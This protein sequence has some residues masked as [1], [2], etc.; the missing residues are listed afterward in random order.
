MT[1]IGDKVKIDATVRSL[2]DDEIIE[3][4]IKA[5]NIERIG[6]DGDKVTF[7]IKRSEHPEIEELELGDEEIT[8]SEIMT[9]IDEDK[10]PRELTGGYG[11]NKATE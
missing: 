5:V 2:I 6:F 4:G 11:G 3:L 8:T 7:Q 1:G 9:G 10:L